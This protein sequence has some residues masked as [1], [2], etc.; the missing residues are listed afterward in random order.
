MYSCIFESDLDERAYFE[1]V[2]FMR[3]AEWDDYYR[4][5][6]E[7]EQLTASEGNFLEG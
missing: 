3:Q 6:V 7:D 4:R 5:W 1:Y 2:E